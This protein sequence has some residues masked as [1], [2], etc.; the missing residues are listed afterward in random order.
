MEVF[1]ETKVISKSE[2]HP[3]GSAW[4]SVLLILLLCLPASAQ[5]PNPAQFQ[6]RFFSGAGDPEYLRLLDISRRMF[7]P[8]AEFQNLSMLYMPSWNGLVEGPT[9][10]ACGFKIAMAPLT[11]PCRFSRSHS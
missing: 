11:P 5:T 7:G 3:W 8:D 6:G 10:D 9:W 1:V 4:A 2:D